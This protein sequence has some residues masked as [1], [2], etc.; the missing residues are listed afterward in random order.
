MYYKLFN[1]L[2]ISITVKI[3][4]ISIQI[5]IFLARAHVGTINKF[6][7]LLEYPSVATEPTHCLPLFFLPYLRWHILDICQLHIR[8]I[9]CLLSAGYIFLSLSTVHLTRN[10][11]VNLPFIMK[12]NV[13]KYQ[14][15]LTVLPDKPKR[16]W[17]EYQR[18]IV[19]VL[20]IIIKF[21][22]C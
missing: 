3:N 21:E 8:S 22:V 5:F 11:K 20:K 16:K 6:I 17:G 13:T 19:V 1:W 15:A 10:C 14:I 18:E 2:W 12:C 4:F 7:S 9:P